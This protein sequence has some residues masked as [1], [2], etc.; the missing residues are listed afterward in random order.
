MSTKPRVYQSTLTGKWVCIGNALY[1]SA[2]GLGESIAE[3][4]S[5][6]LR[7]REEIIEFAQGEVA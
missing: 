6:F 3:A 5:D 2:I 4:Y 1:R 7:E